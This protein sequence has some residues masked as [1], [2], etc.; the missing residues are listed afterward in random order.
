LPAVAIVIEKGAAGAKGFREQ[1]APVGS[2][3][4]AKMNPRGA[5]HVCELE[6]K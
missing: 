2:I 4:V 5:R 6:T 3:V 1:L